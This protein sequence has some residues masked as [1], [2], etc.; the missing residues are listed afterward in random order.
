[1]E[2]INLIN[3]TL[4]A[5]FEKHRS[6][7]EIPAKDVMPEFIKAGIFVKDQKK[8]LPI[9]K[10][11]RDLDTKNQLHLIPFVYA[12]R[13]TK[14]VNWFFRRNTSTN[15][16]KPK[17]TITKIQ[18]PKSITKTSDRDEAYV[19]DLCDEV[20]KQRGARQHKFD[21]LVGDSGTR[22]PVD[23]FYKDLDLVVEYREYQHTN[24]VKFFDKPDKLTVSGVTRGEQRKLYDQRRRHVLPEHGI[25]LIELDY[26]DFDYDRRNR[27]VRNRE[28]DL[29]LIMEV[30]GGYKI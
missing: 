18:V 4:K 7:L 30:L 22:L 26:T 20:L 15:F 28:R 3:Q 24:E 29:S 10:V 8:G 9:R 13:K 1:M 11:L 16:S 21:F 5:Y 19:L 27:I 14:N 17:E 23:V 6:V 2:K 25:K 12:D